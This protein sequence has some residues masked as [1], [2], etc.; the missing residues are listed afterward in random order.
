MKLSIV[1]TLGIGALLWLIGYLASLVLFF[2]PYA[3]IM[4]WIITVSFTPVAI[5]VVWWRFRERGLRMGD[6]A[7][8]GFAWTAIAMVLDY[9]FIFRLFQASYYTA[10]VFVYYALTFLIPVGV[11]FYLV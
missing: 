3:E 1:D 11:G 6:F 9:L 10:D 5:A 7:V 2:S 8:I 4:G